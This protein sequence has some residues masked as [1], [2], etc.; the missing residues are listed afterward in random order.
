MTPCLA[1]NFS[2]D[3]AGTTCHHATFNLRTRLCMHLL[4][5]KAVSEYIGL[6]GANGLWRR[7][8]CKKTCLYLLL[9]YKGMSVCSVSHRKTCLCAAVT[10]TFA[11]ALSGA[12]CFHAKVSTIR[13]VHS[14]VHTLNRRVSAHFLTYEDMSRYSLAPTFPSLRLV[15]T[16][17]GASAL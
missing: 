16:N 7:V 8:H 6:A 12:E 13:R 2:I 9:A 3:V 4:T 15:R 17:Y 5:Y 1:P 11:Y 14:Q 10:Y